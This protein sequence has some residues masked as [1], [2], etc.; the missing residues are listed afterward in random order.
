M[1][2]TVFNMIMWLPCGRK[3]LDKEVK[4]AREDFYHRIK[5]R[6]KNAVYKLPEKPMHEETIMQRIKSGSEE[7]KKYYRD[8]GKMSGG[9][10]TAKDEHWDFISDVM[11]Q[12]IESNP[13][14][15]T[16]FANIGQLESE[17]IKVTLDLFNAP[18]DACGL[19]TSGGTESIFIAMLAYREW[20]RKK[21]ITNP[22]VVAP[23]T[24]HAAFDK[25]CFYL[26]M[27]LRKIKL[28]KDFTVDIH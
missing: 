15:F 7:A 10:Y 14:H 26:G 21:G 8:G 23:V 20:G 27:E 19:T 9:V 2:L 22:N 18:Q 1:K 24:A 13:L 12:N 3:Y 11:R 4:K 25:A 6:R 5:N 28:K 16:E 17:V